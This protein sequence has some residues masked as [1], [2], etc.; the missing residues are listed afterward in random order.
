MPRSIAST[1][2]VAVAILAASAPLAAQQPKYP[3]QVAVDGGILV[4]Y[5]PQPDSLRG[6]PG[7]MPASSSR[8]PGEAASRCS[9]PCG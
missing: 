6:G 3:R 8:G 2:P 4:F 1:L 5:Q 9:A 7:S